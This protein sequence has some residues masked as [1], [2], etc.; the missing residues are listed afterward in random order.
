CRLAADGQGGRNDRSGQ[1]AHQGSRRALLSDRRSGMG[2]CRMT[3]PKFVDPGDWD[4]EALIDAIGA[5]GDSRRRAALAVLAHHLTVEIRL[6]LD[7]PA[8]GSAINRLRL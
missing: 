2:A 5:L 8:S 7:E 3:S 4:V 1:H 6:A